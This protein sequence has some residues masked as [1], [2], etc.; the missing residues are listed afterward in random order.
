MSSVATSTIYIHSRFARHNY[1]GRRRN[2]ADLAK[3]SEDTFF[4]LMF[5]IFVLAGS[6]GV[7]SVAHS[8]GMIRF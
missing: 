1:T 6:T 7:I 2:V 3:R 4:A 8:M 5:G